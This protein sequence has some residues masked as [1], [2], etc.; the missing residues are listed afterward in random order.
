MITEA[1]DD[2]PASVVVKA[3]GFEVN[4]ANS[5]MVGRTHMASNGLVERG[6]WLQ[7]EPHL[8]VGAFRTPF[9]SSYLNSVIF[10]ASQLL[11]Y[12][13]DPMLAERIATCGLP[14]VPVD[15]FTASDQLS[16]NIRLAEVDPEWRKQLQAVA[17]PVPHAVL[18]A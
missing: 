2:I 6:L 13:R 8:D 7:V 11:R 15:T 4:S 3:V 17:P 18:R 10:H 9:G 12:W 1:G 5:T 14:R 16:G